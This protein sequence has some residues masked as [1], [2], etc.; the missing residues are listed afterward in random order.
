M[1]NR[2]IIALA[3]FVPLAGLA[4]ADAP[5]KLDWGRYLGMTEAELTAAG[6]PFKPERTRFHSHRVTLYGQPAEGLLFF[7]NGRP[8]EIVV[9]MHGCKAVLAMRDSLS[10]AYGVEIDDQ[11]PPEHIS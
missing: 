5:A 6:A 9:S 10:R 8:N 1:S 2:A 3:L 11:G 4:T 7:E